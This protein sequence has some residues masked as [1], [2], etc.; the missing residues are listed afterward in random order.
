[1]WDQMLVAP[2]THHTFMYTRSTTS[3]IV[4]VFAFEKLLIKAIILLQ[5]TKFTEFYSTIL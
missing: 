4:V 2:P 1:M 5:I 3:F